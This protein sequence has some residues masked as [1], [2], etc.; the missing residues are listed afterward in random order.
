MCGCTYLTTARR[1]KAGIEEAKRRHKQTMDRHFNTNNT[2]DMWQ[3]IQNITGYK[4]MSI[5]P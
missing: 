4:S 1:L 3:A 2:K 5:P